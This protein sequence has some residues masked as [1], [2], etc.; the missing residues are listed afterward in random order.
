VDTN[1]LDEN[2]WLNGDG[3]PH[4]A[5]ARVQERFTRVDH[6]DLQL[7]VTVTDPKLYSKPFVLGTSSFKWLPKQNL[8]EQLCIPSDMIQ[9]L[10]LI[11]DPGGKGVK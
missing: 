7:T 5:D 8:D 1:G 11:G 3:Y 10:S 4:S 9:Y 6:N 2:T